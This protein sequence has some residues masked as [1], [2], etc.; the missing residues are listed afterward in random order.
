M[1]QNSEE[2]LYATYNLAH[3]ERERER[4]REAADTYSLVTEL[5]ERIGQVE[6]Q[7][8][9]LAG[10]GL[11]K[12]LSGDV[13]AARESFQRAAPMM[14]RLLEWFQGRELMEA[15]EIHLLLSDNRITEAAELFERAI[16]AAR[17]SDVYGAAWLTAE[18]GETFRDQLPLEIEAAVRDYARRPEVLGNP[19]MRE[20]L[21]ALKFDG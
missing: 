21:T 4:L 5:A 17:P 16:A 1:V 2:Q 14:E 8:G 10:L 13:D 11:C 9:A 18:F 15:L 6:V 12:L 7:A 20:R 19:R 3:L